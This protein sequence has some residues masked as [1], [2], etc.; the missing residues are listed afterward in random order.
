VRAGPELAAHPVLPPSPSL[1][2]DNHFR[3]L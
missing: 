2:W 3:R 1:S